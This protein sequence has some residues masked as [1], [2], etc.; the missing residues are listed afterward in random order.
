MKYDPRIREL[1]LSIKQDKAYGD[2]AI[3][4]LSREIRLKTIHLIVAA[5]L[6]IISLIALVSAVIIIYNKL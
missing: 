5:I 1:V 2:Q 3:T 6:E 4:H